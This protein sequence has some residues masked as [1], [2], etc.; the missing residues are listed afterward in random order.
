MRRIF[1]LRRV[2][3]VATSSTRSISSTGS[4]RI[5]PNSFRSIQRPLSTSTRLQ[6]PEAATERREFQAETKKLLDIVANSLYSDQEVFIRELISN[7]SDALEKRRYLEAS[8]GGDQS[9]AE[10]V[11]YEIRITTETDG[12]V[13]E[14]TGVG[15][16]KEELI[17]LLGTIARSGS[18][19]FR[20]EKEAESAQSIIGQFGVGFYS[21]FMVANKVTLTTRKHDPDAVGYKWTW[22]GSSEY[23]IA[24]APD[25]QPGC[26]I[27]LHLRNDD[28]MRFATEDEVKEIINKYSYF[29][30][31][32]ILLNGEQI[33]QMKAIWT[34]NNNEIT[35]EMH[36]AFFRQLAKTHHPHL[37]NDRPQYVIHYKADAPL[38]LRTLLYIPSHKVSQLEFASDSEQSGV[39]LYARKV[40]IKACAKELLPRWLR[41]LVGVVDSEDIPLNLSREMLQK[42]TIVIKLRQLI[43]ER[44]VRFLSQEM[45]KNREKYNEFYSS[46]SMYFKEGL[47]MEQDHSVKEL[48][49][50]VLQY[51]SS[52]FKSGT[53]TSLEEY[54]E[55]MQEGQDTIYYL[56]AP[57]RQLAAHSPY[58]EAFKKQ[59]KEALFVYDAAD[60]LV[61]LVMNEFKGKKLMSVEAYVKQE[62]L[63]SETETSEIVR[64]SSKKELLDWIA[65]SLG[66]VKVSEIKPTNNPTSDYPFVLTALN[67]SAMR[68]V[69]RVS[70]PKEMEHL[71]N[72][73]PV[74]HVNFG[75][76][77]VK[78]LSKLRRSNE[79]LAKEI[80]D[81]VYDNALVTAGLAKETNEFVP[82]VNRILGELLQQSSGSTILTP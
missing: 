36:E 21:A 1:P 63:L 78:G 31:V 77:V 51:E 30:T 80:I 64:D 39:S 17:N 19:E 42:D 52:D 60:E 69:L 56:F 41:F 55:R 48:I 33:N 7:A 24:E 67:H 44:V 46:Y 74:L 35:K 73:K 16:N 25:A 23:E 68:H 65:T 8:T 32:P 10:G 66:S 61:L 34:M 47:V 57:S 15:M 43:T 38:N 4:L 59:N 26:R 81:Q 71:V 70:Q 76:P 20:G 22:D 75:H 29:V 28:S 27:K 50:R 58:F 18:S 2:L 9:D 54:V 53:F 49:A 62:G 14:D 45:K 11:P 37:V 72:I 12:L 6:N 3:Y 5:V 40:L 13:I 79:K 82:R